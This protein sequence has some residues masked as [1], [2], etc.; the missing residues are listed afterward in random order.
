MTVNSDPHHTR[1]PSSIVTLLTEDR[2][3]HSDLPTHLLPSLITRIRHVSLIQAVLTCFVLAFSYAANYRYISTLHYEEDF[4]THALR[5]SVVIL[6]AG[7]VLLI[8][9]YYKSYFHMGV[10]LGHWERF[11]DFMHSG[12]V[13]YTVTETLIHC[14]VLPPKINWETQIGILGRVS[15]LSISDVVFALNFIRVYHIL[16]AYYW[17]SAFNSPRAYFYSKITDTE[18]HYIW[19]LRSLLKQRSAQTLF[20]L[21]LGLCVVGGICFKSLDYSVPGNNLDTEWTAFWAIVVAEETIGYGDFVPLT[22][23]SR[24]LII[25]CVICGLAIYSIAILLSRIQLDLTHSQTLLYSAIASRNETR[26]IRVTAAVF[27]QRWWRCHLRR[28]HGLPFMFFLIKANRQ[29]HSFRIEYTRVSTLQDVLF[30]DTVRHFERYITDIV[31]STAKEYGDLK[32]LTKQCQEVNRNEF[33]IRL[34][35]KAILSY[36]K[37]Q[38]RVRRG[39]IV[40][41]D[42]E[43]PSQTSRS[44]RSSLKQSTVLYRARDSAFRTVQRLRIARNVHTRHSLTS[45]QHS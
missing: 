5:T 43:H 28:T 22:H 2:Y 45:S 37:G 34:K 31:R 1:N 13:L 32:K 21:W 38:G 33:A 44:Q 12:L 16:R 14:F 30:Y 7:Q 23:I 8:V 27:V 9:E 19:V 42:D 25:I 35:I 26:K 29:L 11:T 4:L 15:T 36:A 3:H 39:S 24:I 17:L 6:S 41:G 40:P 18:R 20:L 10:E